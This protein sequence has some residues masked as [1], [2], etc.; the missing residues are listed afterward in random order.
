MAFLLAGLALFEGNSGCFCLDG[1]SPDMVG[2]VHD[3]ALAESGATRGPPTRTI[4]SP[5]GLSVTIIRNM[6]IWL[7]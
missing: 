5:A 7:T 6:S 4:I 1:S 2:R 3:S